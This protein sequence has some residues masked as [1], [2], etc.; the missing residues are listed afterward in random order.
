MGVSGGNHKVHD[1]TLIV[2]RPSRN[3][4]IDFS[5]AEENQNEYTSHRM[6]GERRVFTPRPGETMKRAMVC[7]CAWLLVLGGSFLVRAD[8][9]DAAET[10]GTTPLWIRHPAISP[11]GK[12]IAF[13]YGGQLWLVGADGGEATPLTSGD[14]YSTR[15]VWSP[16]GQ[17]IAFAC[18]RNG[19]FDVFVTPADGG[20][21]L[22]L[23]HHSADDL[24]HAFSADGR[25]I[26]FGSSRIGSPETELVGSFHKNQQLYTVPATGGVVKLLLSTPALDVASSPDG[27]TLVYDSCPVY[28]NE[29][30]KG[31]VSD[32][33]RDLWLFDVVAGTH[34]QLT[35]NRGEDR[36]G[37]FAPDGAS[38][39]YI[40]EQNGGS[41]NVYHVALTNGAIPQPVTHHQG[42]PVR[43]VSADQNGTLVYVYDGSIWRHDAESGEARPLDIHIRQSPLVSGTFSA[44]AL[45]Y[46]S[47]IVV[48]PDGSELAIVARGEMFVVSTANGQ[49]RRITTTP[50]FEQHVSFSPDGR[51][52]LYVSERD[53]A[54]E[55]YEVSLPEGRTGFA[56]PGK[57][58]EVKLIAS[59]VDLL[60]PS[61]SPDGKRIAY[62]E[63]RN[64]I[65]IWDRE[66]N[67]TTE[68]L[69]PGHLYSYLDG[70]HQFVWSPDGRFIL[71]TVGSIAGDMDIALCDARGEEAP[72][73]LSKSGY[74]NMNPYFMPDGHAVLWSSDREGLRS[75]EGDGRQADLFIAH[76]TQES[77]AAFKQ[78]RAGTAT[79][80]EK[81]TNESA[82]PWQPQTDSIRHRITRLTPYS[83]DN[84]VSIK[85][86]P[87]GQAV[88]VLAVNGLGQLAGYRIG[89]TEPSFTQLF[90]KPLTYVNVTMNDEGTALYG[91]GPGGLDKLTLADGRS[92]PIPFSA[93]MDYDPRGEMAWLFQHLWQMTKLKFYEPAM[94]GRDWETIRSDYAQYLPGLQTW[95]DFCDLLGEMAGELNASHMG[96]FWLHQ[97]ELADAT[98]ALGLYTDS[99]YAGPG[100][101]I[102]QVLAGGPCDLTVHPIATGSVITE[103]NGVPVLH[104]E[105]LHEMLNH[106][107]GTPVELTMLA[108]AGGEPEQIVVT[109]VGLAE[110]KELAVDQW[111]ARRREWTSQQ[112]NGRLGYLYISAMDGANYQHAVDY[113]FGEGRDKDG[114]VI[115]VRYNRGGNLHDQLVA[116][117]TG[118]VTADFYA[119]DG[120]HASRIPSD[121]WG[122]PSILLVNAASY[123][124]GSIF[125]HL[126]QRMN[127]GPIVGARVPGTGTAVWWMELLNKNIKYGIPQ[128]GAKDR[129]SG[130]FENN[131]TVPDILV[132]N[133]PED[134]A[135]G[136]DPQLNAAIDHLLK[137]LPTSGGTDEKPSNQ[138]TQ[139]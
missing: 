127:I 122:K 47:E 23:T 30:R 54:S 73:N 93:Q 2:P 17:T 66:Q 32:G 136:R 53:G 117:F 49:S 101:N 83:L 62:L 108:P 31:A 44:N 46:A 134:V 102:K 7:V 81:A 74:G 27:K 9:L 20:T 28:E 82:T 45:R 131:E 135:A 33:T 106:K 103:M 50:A 119:R 65:K 67:T 71:T 91:I 87:D 128:L 130:W 115:D 138:E 43:F 41:F 124:D 55:V 123:S 22:R 113:V 1:I 39:Y 116:L 92:S 63:N 72:V 34:R 3:V 79:A 25:T 110:E 94:H 4:A 139:R 114:I 57:L 36:D 111:M 59:E 6:C 10:T 120:F 14:F 90:V 37:F 60:F 121:R 26:Y 105:H 86:F 78:A 75:S 112:S 42:R 77:Y 89:I 18:K 129:V 70:D 11:D 137:E 132:Y 5:L 48:R 107:A 64:R 88:L 13:A 96:C 97:P 51:R 126:Y 80:T 52:L 85:A 21:P 61:Y 19:H 16:D 29:W 56:S 68:P 99:E 98:A 15:P 84:V 104:D 95:E 58:E 38:V 100:I 125:P 109:P 118:D 12:T 24:P 133:N 8:R 40:S 76:L 69:P 35:S